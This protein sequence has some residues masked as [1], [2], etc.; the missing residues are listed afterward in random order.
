MS[1]RLAS[2]VTHPANPRKILGDLTDLETS[3][4]EVGVIQPPVVL[5]AARVAAAWPAHAE[6]LAGAEW[7]VLVGARRRTAAGRIY[8]D[9]PDATLDVLVRED[10]IADDPLAQL[11]VMTAENVARAPL[12]PVEEARAFAEQEAAGRTQR[13]IAAK[14]GCSQSHV[15]KR[16]KLLRLPEVMLAELET[17][18]SPDDGDQEQR[19]RRKPALQIKDA[20]AFIDA[21]GDDQELMLTAYRL[22]DDRRHHWTP[23]Q[24]V[25]EVRRDRERQEQVDA[26][27]KKLAAEGVP[28]I[29]SAMQ[30]FGDGYWQRRLDGAKAIAKARKDGA[31]VAEVNTW[32]Q[33]TYYLT[34]GKPKAADNRTPAEQKRITDERERRKAMTA[35]AEAAAALAAQAPKLPQTAADIVDAWLWAPGNECAQLAHKWLLAVGVGPEPSLPN[36]QWWEQVRRADWP[37]RVHAAHALGLARREVQARATYRSWTSTDA[38]WLAR[39][40]EEAGYTPSAWEQARLD[41]IDP[42]EAAPDVEPAGTPERVSLVFDADD[43]CCWVLHYDLQVDEPAAYAEHLTD[44]GDVEAAQAWAAELLADRHRI[45]ATGWTD[46]QLLPGRRARIAVHAGDAMAAAGTVGEW[47]LLH[48]AVDDVWLLLADDKPHADHDGLGAAE[49][50]QA[51]QWASGVLADA[52]VV[53]HGWTARADGNAVLEYVADL[54]GEC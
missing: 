26:A 15:S 24:L 2:V 48:D 1:A 36:Y 10:G 5:P 8:G 33:I 16:L 12:I 43:A 52:A 51:C 38:A 37:T 41:A 18:Q 29:D 28:V 42:P 9:D 14:V 34:A 25:T 50:D 23:V 4:R 11:D 45:E 3:I 44:A 46:G 6:K 54:T 7:V 27:T 13:E 17:G 49:V 40:T 30:K 39:L 35:R 20:L 22:R 31:L 53:C 32:G 21:A 19:G 47:R